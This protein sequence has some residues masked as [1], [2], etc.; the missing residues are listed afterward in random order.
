MKLLQEAVIKSDFDI[1][2]TKH[3]V[4]S[5]STAHKLEYKTEEVKV[6]VGSCKC[7]AR[8]TNKSRNVRCGH[9]CGC[10]RNNRRCSSACTCSNK[11]PN[12]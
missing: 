6:V 11:C 7:G 9:M 1:N 10:I 8:T 2:S 4:V 5:V 12:R 3:K